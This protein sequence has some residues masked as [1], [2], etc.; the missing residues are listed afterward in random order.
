MAAQSRMPTESDG[1][2]AMSYDLMVF[3]PDA[4]PS[5]ERDQ[6][7]DWYDS[8]AEWREGHDYDNPAVCTPALRAFYTDLTADFPA[9]SD[10]A[11]TYGTEYT[12]GSVLIYMSFAWDKVDE[13]H[14]AVFRLAARHA[15]GFFDA[16]SD[17][18]ETWLPD[19]KGGL[20]IAHSD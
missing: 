8:Q 13:A 1:D 10:D 19:G 7:L 3:A 2:T 11:D 6:F 17:L 16:S 14:A 9:L 15:I 18:A 20:Y 12:I 4:P 5:E